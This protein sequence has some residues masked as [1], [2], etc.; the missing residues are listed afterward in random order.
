MVLPL[1]Y[2]RKSHRGTVEPITC[3][4]PGTTAYLNYL[5][6]LFNNYYCWISLQLPKH[7]LRKCID[8]KSHKKKESCQRPS[9]TASSRNFISFDVI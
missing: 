5:R 7:E 1:T 6:I 3:E 2:A 9:T 8:Y 4:S